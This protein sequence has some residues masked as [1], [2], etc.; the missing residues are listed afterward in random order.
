VINIEELGNRIRVRRRK[1]RLTQHDIARALQ[2][3]PQAVSKWERGENAPDIGVLAALARLLGVSTD[4]LLGSRTEKRDVF[5]A[6]VFASGVKSAREV[7]EAI[8]P[9]EFAAW[10]NAVC[11]QVTE[12]VL[13]HDGIPVKYT[14][15]GQLAFFS[16]IRHRER[17]VDA[18]NA[19]RQTS[20]VPLKLG[21]CSGLVYYGAIGHPDYLQPDIM[22]ETVSIALL[23][24]D[25]AAENIRSGTAVC[26]M[27]ED[28]SNLS[29][30]DG[31]AEE[32][33]FPGISHTVFLNEIPAEKGGEDLAC[34]Q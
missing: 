10:T 19:A 15:P 2:V 5:E 33:Q 23:S 28:R 9:S 11:F 20:A 34:R 7:S 1:C 13:R 27:L 21:L 16:G 29:G 12:A 8:T 17:A 25:W 14:G 30:A 32:V 31:L 26:S 4:W 22:G 24:C 3:S 18:A 6:T